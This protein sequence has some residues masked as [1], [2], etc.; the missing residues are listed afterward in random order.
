MKVEDKVD[1]KVIQQIEV[2]R[3]FSSGILADI[4]RYIN[5]N[6]I[7]RQDT[8]NLMVVIDK[9]VTDI[10]DGVYSI[11]TMKEAYIVRGKLQIINEVIKELDSK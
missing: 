9:I 1:Y 2:L 8:T 7:D 10:W 4:S 3:E 11:K 5:E 6:N